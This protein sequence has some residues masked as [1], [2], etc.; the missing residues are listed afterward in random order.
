MGREGGHDLRG[1]VQ[2]AKWSAALMLYI[3]VL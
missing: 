2:H 3:A 1:I